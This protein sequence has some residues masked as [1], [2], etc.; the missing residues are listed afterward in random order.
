MR[1]RELHHDTA[2]SNSVQGENERA[3]VSDVVGHVM[4][5]HEIGVAGLISD[6]RP[7]A[8]NTSGLDAASRSLFDEEV[9]HGTR[10]IDADRF[11]ETISDGHRCRTATTADIDYR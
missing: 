3:E 4:A 6:G 8:D 11:M 5:Q 9:E 2:A 1:E 10:L 7:G